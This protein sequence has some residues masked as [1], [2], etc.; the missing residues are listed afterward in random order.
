M[1]FLLHRHFALLERPAELAGEAFALG[2]MLPDLLRLVAPRRSLL[3]ANA[4][5]AMRAHSDADVRVVGEGVSHH[6]AIDRWFHGCAVFE[7]G[8]RALK[9]RFLAT[10]T[11]RLLLFAHPAFEMCL[12]GAWLRVHAPTGGGVGPRATDAL[13]LVGEA[14]RLGEIAVDAARLRRVL[15]ALEDGLLHDDYRSSEGIARRVGGM[16]M[17][18]GFGPPT[19]DDLARWTDALVPSAVEADGALGALER[20]RASSLARGGT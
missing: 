11:K 16:R 3:R 9:D 17:A 2:A 6:H 5:D 14:A 7:A 10:N 13:P 1:N 8:E 20:D 19:A 12:D 15:A 4:I 18:F